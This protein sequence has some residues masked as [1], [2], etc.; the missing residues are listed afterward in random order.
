MIIIVSSN[1]IKY[2]NFFVVGFSSNV[3]R[4]KKKKNEVFFKMKIK[5]V[6]SND[7]GEQKKDV[8]VK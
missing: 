8:E 6:R 5:K 2:D 7:P 1:K 3:R 4:G